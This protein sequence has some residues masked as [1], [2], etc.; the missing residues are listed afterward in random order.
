MGENMEFRITGLSKTIGNKK[1]LDGLNLLLKSGDVMA[2]KGNN[3][4]GKT[5]LLKIIAGIDKDFDG[6]IEFDKDLNIGYVPQDIVLFEQLSVKD[7]LQAFC[8]GKDAKTNYRRLESYAKEL[9]INDLFKKKAGRLSGGQ[10]RLVN[11]LV[12][13]TNSPDLMLFDEII[14]GMDED[15]ITKVI[16]LINSIKSD[17]IIIITSHQTDFTKAVCNISGKL[18]GGKLEFS[19]EG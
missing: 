10:K 9:G 3:G 16:Q 4:S 13:L 14:V 12:G 1:I 19:Y 18:T 5:S 11:F 15:T 8:N 17:K 7:N 2:L 6:K